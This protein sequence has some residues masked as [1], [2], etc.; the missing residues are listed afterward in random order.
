MSWFYTRG[1][2]ATVKYLKWL[3]NRTISFYPSDV[4]SEADAG[5]TISILIFGSAPKPT[6]FGPGDP[7]PE[8]LYGSS[9]IARVI[10][11]HR[12]VF[13]RAARPALKRITALLTDL[14][15]FGFS[16]ARERIA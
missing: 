2:I 9:P 5:S 13:T 11:L 7:F 16:H 10:A 15:D 4:V 3:W 12:A 8:T 1:V 6:G 14:D